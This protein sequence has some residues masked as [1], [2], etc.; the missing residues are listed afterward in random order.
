MGRGS[1]K[2]GGGGGGR[3][4]QK[5]KEKIIKGIQT[6]TDAENDGAAKNYESAIEKEKKTL[7][8]IEKAVK[9][10]AL[11][12]DDPRI[13]YHKDALESLENQYAYFK[14]QRKKL[15]KNSDEVPFAE[16]ASTSKN[17]KG[18]A[19][20]VMI[21]RN[22]KGDYIFKGN[23][24]KAS[25]IKID[26][27]SQDY[28]DTLKQYNVK[29]AFNSDG[30]VTV[31][32]GGLYGKKQT[33]KTDDAF[34][35]DASKKLDTMKQHY[36]KSLDRR[37]KGFMPQIEA[38]NMK[39]SMSKMFTTTTNRQSMSKQFTKEMK[40][41]KTHVTAI[42]DMQSRLVTFIKSSGTKKTTTSKKYTAKDVQGMTRAKLESAALKAF[43]RINT[44][45]GLTA[46]EATR[47]AKALMSG[48]TTAQLRKYVQKNGRK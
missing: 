46:A 18:S 19:E 3:L 39:T 34:K 38:E 33:F 15:S 7:S 5:D 21:V 26:K 32:R 8:D 30:S 20:N 48:N 27:S 36:Q 1:S 11:K 16:F 4:L 22:A 42:D 23:I 6:H 29:A 12:S 43:V 9:V 35:T 17:P 40:N 25:S 2:A 24:P 14:A 10:G 44:A 47:R 45:A 28:K 37:E 13:A 41:A 31:S